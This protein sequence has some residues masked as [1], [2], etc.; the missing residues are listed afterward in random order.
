LR[1]PSWARRCSADDDPYLWLEE[2][3][4][5]A[6]SPEQGARRPAKFGDALLPRELARRDFRVPRLNAAGK[7]FSRR[8]GET[9]HPHGTP[10]SKK[11]A[12]RKNWALLI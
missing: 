10:E 3:E 7:T 11:R 5:L 2:I 12:Q 9:R 4:A 1:S 6:A 8:Y